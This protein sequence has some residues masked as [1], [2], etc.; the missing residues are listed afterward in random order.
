MNATR[1][2]F[3][4]GFNHF[5]FALLFSFIFNKLLKSKY[6]FTGA[7]WPALIFGSSALFFLPPHINWRFQSVPYYI[8]T[9]LRYPLPD[10]DILV[11]GMAWHRYFL[12]H[13]VL[14]P[15]IL[16]RQVEI[17]QSSVNFIAGLF[18]GMSSHFVWDAITCSMRTP[19]V[20]YSKAFEITGYW[21]K[22]WLIINGILLFII[23]L[24]FVKRHETFVEKRCNT[25]PV[26]A[27]VVK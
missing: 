12:F 2:Y 20:F 23:I 9:Y 14:L 10:W 24:A 13:S 22:S 3:W 6:K 7:Y 18:V 19:I 1:I 5:L 27:E 17:K 8:W 21:A 25:G 26:E 15:L 4:D 11:L 16:F